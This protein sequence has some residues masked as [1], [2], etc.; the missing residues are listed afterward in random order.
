MTLTRFKW[1][2]VALVSQGQFLAAWRPKKSNLIRTDAPVSPT[3]QRR[4]MRKQGHE[5]ALSPRLLYT[6]TP[7]LHT[8]LVL[9]CWLTTYF[10]QLQLHTT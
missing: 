10:G 1:N 8:L 9:A 3:S 4:R 2:E 7:T 5:H 6:S